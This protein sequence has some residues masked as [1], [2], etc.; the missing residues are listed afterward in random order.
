MYGREVYYGL[1]WPV[2]YI[3]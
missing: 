1:D 2:N 3:G